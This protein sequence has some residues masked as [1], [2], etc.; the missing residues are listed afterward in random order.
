MKK[1]R[2]LLA[3]LV[4]LLALTG[5]GKY[6]SSYKAVGFVHSNG[7]TSAEMSFYS[8]EG[9]MVS[10]LNSTGEGDIKYTAKLE[11]GSATIRYEYRGTESELFT[12]GPESEL[13]SHGGYV[14]SGTVTIIVE[15][16]GKC[17]NGSFS[18]R[19]E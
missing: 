11:S 13:E 3:A 16:E 9:R 18:F 19:V 7:R 15:T 12:I 2:L 14:E 8:F 1:T 4:I 17:M 5:C 6:T 10:R